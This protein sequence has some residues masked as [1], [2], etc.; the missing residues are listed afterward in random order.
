LLLFLVLAL[1]TVVGWTVAR[2]HE[3]QLLLTQIEMTAAE[4]GERLSDHLNIRF[5]MREGDPKPVA[6]SQGGRAVE[7]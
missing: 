1:P 6:A 3:R 5:S 4:V 2:G 7:G